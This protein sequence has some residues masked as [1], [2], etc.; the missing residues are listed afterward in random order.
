MARTMRQKAH[1]VVDLLLGLRNPEAREQLAAHGCDAA[2]LD[3]GWRLLSQTT[4]PSVILSVEMFAEWSR[5]A[6]GAITNRRL[7]RELGLRAERRGVKRSPS[8]RGS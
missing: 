7:L 5:I 3:D 1:R 2:D 6:R 8:G 4:G